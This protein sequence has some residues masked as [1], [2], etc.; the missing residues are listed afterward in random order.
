[1]EKIVLYKVSL[2]MVMLYKLIH[3]KIWKGKEYW[4]LLNKPKEDADD[5]SKKEEKFEEEEK[6]PSEPQIP[7]SD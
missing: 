3:L 6:D 7:K 1:M 5:E 2:E 4:K